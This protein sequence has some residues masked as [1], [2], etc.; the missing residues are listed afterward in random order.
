MTMII[1]EDELFPEED[2]D[3]DDNRLDIIEDAREIPFSFSIS[4][5][6]LSFFSHHHQ[7][8]LLL[9]LLARLTIHLHLLVLHFFY[10]VILYVVHVKN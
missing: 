9:L 2:R 4:L 1:V 6:S 10:T 7:H 8:H 3:D 5:F